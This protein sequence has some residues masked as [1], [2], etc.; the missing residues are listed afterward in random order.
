[1]MSSF[2]TRINVYHAERIPRDQP[3]V[4]VSNHRSFLDPALLMV[5]VN[6][7]IRFACHRYM[8][9]VPLL[10]DVVTQMGAFSLDPV[11]TAQ[12]Q[13]GSRRKA[14]VEKA[15]QFLS[16]GDVVGIFPEGAQPMVHKTEPDHLGAFHRGFAHL[17]LRSPIP[18]VT[19]L[20]V[21]IASRQESIHPAFPV[22][23]LHWFDP[24]EPLFD[25]NGWH[26]L[27]VYHAVN[28]MVGTPITVNADDQQGFQGK[29]GRILSRKLTQQCQT[30]VHHLLE[31]GLTL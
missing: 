20:P 7:S 17:L 24:S 8:A 6:Q 1:M 25:Q 21:A 22:R 9:Q 14:L 31:Q 29:Q 19:I 3:V 18:Q 4:I 30:D 2:N 27:V 28:V 11:E 5:A 10:R 23:L 16:A 13:T 15:S 12:G 26:P